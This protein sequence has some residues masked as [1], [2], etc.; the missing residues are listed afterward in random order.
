[1]TQTVPKTLDMNVAILYEK[2]VSRKNL[3][4]LGYQFEHRTERPKRSQYGDNID[5]LS[6]NSHELQA[7][8]ETFDILDTNSVINY[9]YFNRAKTAD[10]L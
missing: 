4:R 9:F 7:Y 1:M 6:S 3:L 2:Q 8:Y 5:L 10:T